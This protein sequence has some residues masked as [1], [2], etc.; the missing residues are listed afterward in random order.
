MKVRHLVDGAVALAMAAGMVLPVDAHAASRPRPAAPA[1]VG[2]LISG[3]SSY[4]DGTYVWTDYAYDDRGPD[5]NPIAGG[6]ATYPS[7]MNPNNVADLIQLQLSMPDDDHLAVGAVLETLTDTTRPLIGVALDSD[8][9]A[10]TGAPSLPG[11]WTASTSLGVDRLLLLG[12][13]GGQDLRWNGVAWIPTTSFAVNIDPAAN[14][15]RATVPFTAPASGTLRAVTALGYDDGAG[16]SWATGAS[17]VYDLGFVVD[18]LPVVPFQQAVAD[19]LT[20]FASGGERQ[21]QDDNQSAILGG[22]KDAAAAVASI[23]VAAMEAHRT[24][25]ADVTAKGFH[26]F[27]YHSELKLTEGVTQVT[28]HGQTSNFYAG[29]YQ[30]YTVWVPGAAPGTSNPYGG[31]P[32]V[33]YLHGSSQTHTSAV[34]TDPYQ[35]GNPFSDFD[36]VV[37]FPLGRGPEAWYEGPALVDPIDVEHDVMTRLSL[38]PERVMLSGLSMG[39]YGTFKLG[40]LYPDRWSIAYVDAAGDET[41]MPEN[42]TALPVRMQNGAADPLVPV[43][44]VTAGRPPPPLGT[45]MALEDAGTVDYRSYY[46]AKETHAA[47]V[48]IA[49]CIYEYSFDHPRV[50]NPARVRYTVDPATFVDDPASGLH[51]EWTGAYWVSGMMPAGGTKGSVDLATDALGT[52]PVPEAPLTPTAYENVSAGRDFCGPNPDVQTQDAWVERGRVVASQPTPR[53]RRLTGTI[54]GLNGVTVAAD[55]ALPGSGPIVIDITADRDTT[56]TL[57]GLGGHRTLLVPLH[58]GPNQLTVG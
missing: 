7:T 34:N 38:D 25:L 36:A 28:T 23:D 42:F 9:N 33:L 58:A 26:T 20:G 51:L 50:T 27:L 52:T 35:A 32:L 30:P 3:T 19:A 14:T 13:D 22:K 31:L 17:P 57:T 48:G 53:Q 16:G 55:R 12:R 39:G 49:K 18:N 6:D 45:P 5:T 37:A 44:E 56:L 10:A 47:A 2:P 8:N 4:V 46:V 41:G 21:W 29:P 40:E 11:S 54:T 15:V 1:T 43:V 24:S